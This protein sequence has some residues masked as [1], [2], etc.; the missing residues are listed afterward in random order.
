MKDPDWHEANEIDN[1][2]ACCCIQV[3]YACDKCKM[4][5]HSEDDEDSD[6]YTLA[7]VLFDKG[8]LAVDG[9]LICPE[10]RTET[11]AK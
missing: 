9:E 1:I 3:W 5:V 8:W 10:C 2:Q 11:E 6:G 4:E 7:E